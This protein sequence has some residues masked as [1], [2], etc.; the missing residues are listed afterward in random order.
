MVSRD[1]ICQ[2]LVQRVTSR[3]SLGRDPRTGGRM[4]DP[5]RCTVKLS[6][7]LVRI[8]AEI[9]QQPG[10]F[11]QGG[12]PEL[13]R[14]LRRQRAHLPRVIGHRLPLRTGLTL[15]RMRKGLFH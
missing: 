14:T 3:K 9:V 4:V 6:L 15:H 1:D 7:E 12:C 10:Y 2:E 13:G 5:Y 11:A 8:L